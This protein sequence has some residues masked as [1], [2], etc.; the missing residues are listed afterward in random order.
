MASVALEQLR[1]KVLGPGESE[2]AQLA[3]DLNA[4]TV[5][6]TERFEAEGET[7]LRINLVAQAQDGRPT[8]PGEAGV[9]VNRSC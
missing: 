1:T 3:H 9:A 7:R 2:R 6:V 8:S 4:C 5:T